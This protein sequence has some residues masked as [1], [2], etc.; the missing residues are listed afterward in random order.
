MSDMPYME[1]VGRQFLSDLN[2]VLEGLNRIDALKAVAKPE[3][4]KKAD[5]YLKLYTQQNLPPKTMKDWRVLRDGM[6]KRLMGK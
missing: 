6:I 1:R 4:V 3:N 2:E 5:A